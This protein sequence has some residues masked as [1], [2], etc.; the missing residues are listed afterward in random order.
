MEQSIFLVKENSCKQ[1]EYIDEEWDA[2]NQPIICYLNSVGINVYR[3]A[4]AKRLSSFPKIII[5][6]V[7][8]FTFALCDI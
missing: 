8:F 5:T 2:V 3:G 6:S 4:S 1:L 7:L